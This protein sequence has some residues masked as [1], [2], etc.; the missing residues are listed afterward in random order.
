MPKFDETENKVIDKKIHEYVITMTFKV[1]KCEENIKQLSKLTFTNQAE[2]SIKNNMKK[3]LAEKIRD[4]THEFRHNE[5]KYMKNYK[6]LVG[7]TE[8]LDFDN[9]GV[10]SGDS[11]ND[12][13]QLSEVDDRLK[14]RDE[15]ITTLLRSIVEL[16]Q[17]FK[18][19]QMLVQEQGTILD[20]IDYNIENALENTQ[21]A[22]KELVKANDYMKK[23]CFRNVIMVLLFIVFVESVLILLKFTK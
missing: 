12:F 16:A 5:E 10:E 19:L 9:K 3:N 18:D 2:E 13:L 17:T 6:E 11:K 7:D 14:K 4:F 8:P 22:H 15:E 20:R 21:V 1:K 23:N